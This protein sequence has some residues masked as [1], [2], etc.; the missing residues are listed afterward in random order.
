MLRTSL[1][2]RVVARVIVRVHQ[3]FFTVTP[4]SSR[5]AARSSCQVFLFSDSLR[6]SFPKESPPTL[7]RYDHD[8]KKGERREEKRREEKKRE[9]GDEMRRGAG[10][11]GGRASKT[12][13]R[14]RERERERDD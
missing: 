9:R 14:E 2:F 4:P 13:A 11:K 12:R 10:V 3:L 8:H 5:V 7:I 1:P 6:F